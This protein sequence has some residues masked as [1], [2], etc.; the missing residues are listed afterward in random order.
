M[1]FRRTT[2]ASVT[3]HMSFYLIISNWIGFRKQIKGNKKLARQK[4]VLDRLTWIRRQGVVS[5]L[6]I[7]VIKIFSAINKPRT[8]LKKTD[9]LTKF[10]VVIHWMWMRV[11]MSTLNLENR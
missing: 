2:C 1:V 9:C 5:E 8:Y 3:A 10:M 7:C 4:K 11:L 6:S